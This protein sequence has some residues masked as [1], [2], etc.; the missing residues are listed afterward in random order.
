MRVDVIVS[1]KQGNAIA[2]L[3]QQD[4]EVT[5]DGK[6]FNSAAVIDADGALLGTYRKLHIPHDPFFYEQSYFEPGDLG[7]RI[8]KTRHLTFAVLICYDQWFPEAARVVSLAGADLIFYP[9]AIGY[10]KGDP[11]PH[12]TWLNA[13]ITIQR[14]R[15]TRR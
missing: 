5:E 1:D 14:S 4:F 2:D 8:F 11:L 9:T 13:W 15:R 7:Y 12:D 3:R 6:Y 10:L